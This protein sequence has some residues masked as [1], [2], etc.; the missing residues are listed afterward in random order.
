[1]TDTGPLATSP[2]PVNARLARRHRSARIC[3]IVCLIL[4]LLLATASVVSLS[5][6]AFG[7][8]GGAY[9]FVACLV[10]LGIPALIL[11]LTIAYLRAFEL[12]WLGVAI[13]L[14]YFAVEVASHILPPVFCSG[15]G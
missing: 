14:I 11:L 10:I 9:V 7:C 13:W 1:M 3:A 8:W 5:T 2:P 6:G 4:V 15:S 12:I